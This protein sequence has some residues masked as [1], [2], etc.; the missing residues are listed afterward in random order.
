MRIYATVPAEA[1]HR[2]TA[3]QTVQLALLS[4]TPP[5]NIRWW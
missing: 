1:T 2:P 3:E 4:D 5:A